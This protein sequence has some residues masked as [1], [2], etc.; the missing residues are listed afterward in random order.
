MTA[1]RRPVL[2][3]TAADT[4]SLTGTRLS[5]VAIPWLVLTMTGDPLLTGLAGFAEM[6]PYVIAKALGGPLIDRLGA[7]RIAIVADLVSMATIALVPLLHLAGLLGLPTILPLVAVL[8]TL[9]GPADAAKYAMVPAVAAAGAL[10]L[11]RV[12][13]IMGVIERL[14]ST[15]GVALAGALVALLGPALALSVTAGAFGLSALIVAVGLPALPQPAPAASSGY[16]ADLREGWRFFRRD[17]VLVGVVIMVASTNLL[18]TAYSSVLL[19]VWS[20]AVGDAALLGLLFAIFSGASIAGAALATVLA[21]R[22]PRLPVYVI[23]FLLTGAPRYLAFAIDSPMPALV[24]VLI[25]GGFASG[26]LNPILSAVMLERIPAALTGRVSALVNAL[27][28]TLIPLGGLF[29]GAL[30]T[31]AGLPAAFAVSGT[32]YLAVT[33]LPLAMRSFRAFAERPAL[34]SPTP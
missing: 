30:I 15:I 1:S 26:F 2:A 31:L 21:E 9:R 13:G 10:P 34:P 28:W 25:V 14:A 5:M 3:L 7:R 11:E 22:L 8:G 12:T 19:P 18:D 17:A 29:G 23:A 27:S 24:V 33:L 4:L 6:L 16:L 20:E 32:I